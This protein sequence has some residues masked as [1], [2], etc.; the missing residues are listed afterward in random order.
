MTWTLLLLATQ[1][2]LAISITFQNQLVL[3][4]L[5]LLPILLLNRGLFRILLRWKLLLFLAVMLG[6][7]PVLL[8]EKSASF[9]GIPYS[10][11]YVQAT[12]V[13]AHR[14]VV[15]LLAL[16]LFTSRLSLDELARVIARTRFRQFGEAFGL[17]MELLPALRSTAVQAYREYRLSL[18]GRGV[19]RHT[20]SWMAELIARA[21]VHAE[22]LQTDKR[23]TG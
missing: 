23:R 19:I 1:L 16:K 4:P 7:V 8:G 20:L 2:L 18:P 22:T 11:E 21:L 9:M 17:S 14:S 3:V 12:V 10:P 6:A 15:I 13:M 5:A